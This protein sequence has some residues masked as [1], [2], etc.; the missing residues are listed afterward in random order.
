MQ[1]IETIRYSR[2]RRGSEMKR[3]IVCLLLM[4]ASPL[5]AVDLEVYG[6]GGGYMFSGNG[7]CRVYQGLTVVDEDIFDTHKPSSTPGYWGL[8]NTSGKESLTMNPEVSRS[9]A[10]AKAQIYCESNW[11]YAGSAGSS[12]PHIG[13]KYMIHTQPR[14]IAQTPD[15]F[16]EARGAVGGQIVRIFSNPQNH[17][18]SGTIMV[19]GSYMQNVASPHWPS[20][21][22]AVFRGIFGDNYVE[23]A[24]QFN[25]K[26][27]ITRRI[28]KVDGTWETA[29][30]GETQSG[31]NVIR[32]VEDPLSFSA[33]GWHSGDLV[34]TQCYLSK[35]TD[36]RND[37]AWKW[38]T[39]MESEATNGNIT[40]I[41][42]QR[43]DVWQGTVKVTPG[44]DTPES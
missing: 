38:L 29:G 35:N 15:Y 23:A 43:D 40:G 22:S 20:D 32:I 39:D 31:L 16:S 18:V 26:W 6:T 25:K 30:P 12:N 27:K 11:T 13:M 14:V 21:M 5:H 37:S 44:F 2:C 36:P 17:N 1:R 34:V 10:E 3:L 8:L 28:R 4:L 19:T 33:T 7:H 24:W 42:Q 9:F 41:P